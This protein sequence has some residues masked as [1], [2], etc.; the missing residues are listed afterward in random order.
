MHSLQ[1]EPCEVMIEGP[2]NQIVTHEENMMKSAGKTL[3]YTFKENEEGSHWT[4]Q[5]RTWS[6]SEACMIVNRIGY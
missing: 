6:N 4:L 2:R 1:D 3:D 5:M